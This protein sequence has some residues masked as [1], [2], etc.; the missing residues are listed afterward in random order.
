MVRILVKN[1]LKFKEIDLT[2]VNW[3]NVSVQDGLSLKEKR[4][5]LPLESNESIKLNLIIFENASKER[6]SIIQIIQ[7][8]I[9]AWTLNWL[10]LNF[11]GFTVV[12][13]KIS[14]KGKV[15]SGLIR[16]RGQFAQGYVLLAVWWVPVWPFVPYTSPTIKCFIQLEC[17]LFL[18]ANGVCT[19]YK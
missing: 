5:N 18:T 17:V 3:R 1:T 6:E 13:W 2:V 16:K 12:T 14:M 4:G 8:S 7:R 9:S 19:A 11:C 10:K 15:S